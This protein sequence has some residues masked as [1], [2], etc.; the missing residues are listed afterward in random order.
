M[1]ESVA[2]VE[3]VAEA[4]AV[5]EIVATAAAVDETVAAAVEIVAA[6]AAETVVVVEIAGVATFVGYIADLHLVELH[7]NLPR[8]FH[9]FVGAEC[10]CEDRYLPYNS[11]VIF[12]TVIL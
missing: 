6:A 12:E 11:F 3:I 4:A 5:D 9:L 1:A 7:M 10:C 2:A 8:N